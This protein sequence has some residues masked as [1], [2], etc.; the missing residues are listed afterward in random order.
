MK[1]TQKYRKLY[2]EQSQE[3][4]EK[5]GY[6]HPPRNWEE[7]EEKNIKVVGKYLTTERFKEEQTT[8]EIQVKLYLNL[9]GDNLKHFGF[10]TVFDKNHFEEINDV[11]FQTSRNKLLLRATTASGTDHT[12]SLMDALSAFSCNDFEIIDSFFPKNLFSENVYFP[13]ICVNLLNVIYHKQTN[14]AQEALQRADKFLKKKNTTWDKNIVLY[15]LA[16][17]HRDVSEANEAL[18]NLCTAYQKMEHSVMSIYNKMEKC[19]A[20]EIHGLY[21]L[22]KLIDEEFFENLTIPKHHCF[23]Q[24]FE[25][26]HKENNYPK[27]KIF[28]AYPQEMDYLN[29]IYR[30]KIPKV[31]L[32]KHKSTPKLM[33]DVELFAQ[34]LAESVAFV[35][36]SENLKSIAKNTDATE[37]TSIT[38]KLFKFFGK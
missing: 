12:I 34:E 21:R 24:E 13:S 18:Q 16:L 27:G 25:L 30:A 9:L 31:T 17:Y 37:K 38:Q 32:K 1:N 5:W 22:A 6:Y 28:Y 14:S 36:P 19:F 3:S 4:F 8:P 10:F 33:K 29:R 26:W 20:T 2:L 15:F 35:P 23:F 7:F 11:I